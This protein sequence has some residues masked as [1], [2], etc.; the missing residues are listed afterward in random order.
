VQADFGAHVPEENILR[1]VIEEG[2]V[3]KNSSDLQLMLRDM[4]ETTY[5]IYNHNQD[6]D[7]DVL[8]LVAVRETED[9]SSGGLLYERIRHYDERE[10]LK[11]FGLDLVEFLELPTDLVTYLLELASKKQASNHKVAADVEEGI[12]KQLS[13]F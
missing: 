11:F 9:S 2:P 4:Y 8:S 6:T 1:K 5:G 7:D 12:H 3:I 10:I 13:L